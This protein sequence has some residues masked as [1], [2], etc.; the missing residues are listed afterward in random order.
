[1]VDPNPSLGIHI[2]R[3]EMSSTKLVPVPRNFSGDFGGKKV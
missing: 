1:M 3:R 2:M